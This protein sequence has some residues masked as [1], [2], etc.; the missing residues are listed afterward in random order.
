MKPLWNWN[1][2]FSGMIDWLSYLYIA[3][4]TITLLFSFSVMLRAVILKCNKRPY[5]HLEK[6]NRQLI[7]LFIILM[8][9]LITQAI[10]W[11]AEGMTL[12]EDLNNVNNIILQVSNEALHS[13]ILLFVLTFFHTIIFWKEDSNSDKTLNNGGYSGP[14]TPR[15]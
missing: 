7:L 4:M 14:A 9:V 11:F 13:L 1:F 10:N 8:S 15:R 5:K 2:L 6:L 3:L 12:I